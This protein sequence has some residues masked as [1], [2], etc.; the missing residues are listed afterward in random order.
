MYLPI[1][2]PRSTFLLA[3]SLAAP[4][5][6]IFNPLGSDSSYASRGFDSRKNSENEA[7]Y[8][9]TSDVKMVLHFQ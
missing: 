3:Y 4:Y 5:F 8:K 2:Q 6:I 9:F 7:G 1:F